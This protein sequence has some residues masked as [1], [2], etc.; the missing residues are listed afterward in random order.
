MGCGPVV[1][2]V[3]VQSLSFTFPERGTLPGDDKQLAVALQLIDSVLLN[4][5]FAVR[6]T[7]NG[8]FLRAYHHNR[9]GISVTV[10]PLPN[11]FEV[12]FLQRGARGISDVAR[13]AQRD[14][15]AKLRE[16]F[17]ERIAVAEES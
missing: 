17:G 1:D 16:V 15:K 9:V 3:S 12:S 10:L 14:L 11:G 4:E 2:P 7:E 13:N 8:R 6:D 5:R